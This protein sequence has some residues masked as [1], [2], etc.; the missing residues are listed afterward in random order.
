MLERKP[1][2]GWEGLN[3]F[4]RSLYKDTYFLENENY[5]EWMH[6]IT[7]RIV[8]DEQKL[9]RIKTYINNYW[10]QPSTPI[11]SGIGLPISCYVSHV[12]DSREGI[13]DAYHEGM[14]LGAE[15][16]GRG[17]DWSAVREQGASVSNKGVS[18]GVIPFLGPSDR[19]TYSITQAGVRRSTEAAYLHISHPDITDFK[20]IRLESGDKNRRMPNLHHGI[21][22][23]DKFLETVEQLG[24]WDLI[25]P[26]TGEVVASV[27]AFDLWIDILEIAKTEAG[28]PYILYL[29]TVNKMA[30]IEYKISGLSVTASNI[31]TEIVTHTSEDKTTIC[32]LGSL[33]LE[34]W[35]EYEDILPQ[36]IADISDMLDD[37]LTFFLKETS[38]LQEAIERFK[39]HK[40][41]RGELLR[42]LAFDKARNAIIEER[43]IGIGVMGFHSMLQ[44]NSIPFES[45][46]AVSLNKKIFKR[47]REE[48]D[49]YQEHICSENPDIRC[50]LSKRCGT[51]R[52]N[53]HAIA[54]APTLSISTLCQLASSG[55]EPW[56]ANAFTKKVPTGSFIIK[57]KFLDALIRE[58][59]KNNGF[60]NYWV[61]TQWSNINKA[62]GSVLGL[63]WMSSYEKDVFKTAFEIDPRATIKLAGDRAPYIDQAQS[64]NIF[65]PAEITYEELYTIHMML[66]KAGV[67][68]RY[69]LRSQPAVTADAGQR[70]RQPITLE[71]DACVACT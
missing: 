61:N 57:N 39:T 4:S 49:A 1:N 66:W 18:S 37:T 23:T 7:S 43:N 68:S 50:E 29:D 32:C 12:P 69:Y 59:A 42:L 38:G 48:S 34:Y 62:N 46:M 45:P 16:G 60:D 51:N 40:D 28:E 35:D 5:D 13:F 22:V 31:C 11:S 55:I 25:S 9:N 2:R 36:V 20:N 44:K 64:L 41:N 70:E 10:F 30:P 63:E 27:D 14:W 15:G 54:I 56:V 21:A 53:I 58:Y 33:N 52:R 67:K 47:I 26:N 65:V 71:D 19:L 3:D 17:V 6:R 24:M 8:K